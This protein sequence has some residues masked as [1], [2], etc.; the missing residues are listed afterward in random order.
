MPALS[1][2]VLPR[3][4]RAVTAGGCLL[5]RLHRRDH[6]AAEQ[7]MREARALSKDA[8][9]DHAALTKHMHETCAAREEAER[10]L[11]M[12]VAMFDQL[13]ADWRRKLKDRRKEVRGRRCAQLKGWPPSGRSQ[14]EG[15]GTCGNYFGACH[16]LSTG[17]RAGEAQG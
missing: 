17:P 3:T 7:Q 13:R 12:T 16:C 2:V 6:Q 10:D 9:D 8:D 5:C 11:G 4:S 15:G 1:L 14:T